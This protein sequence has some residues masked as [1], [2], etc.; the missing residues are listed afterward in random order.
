MPF[1]AYKVA[2]AVVSP[3]SVYRTN[4]ATHTHPQR[5]LSTR[6]EDIG[7][8]F[9][10]TVLSPLS[11]DGGLYL[12]EDTPRLSPS[13]LASWRDLSLREVALKIF[14]IFIS[15]AEIPAEHLAQIV[16]ASLAGIADISPATVTQVDRRY[17]LYI[18]D[19]HHGPGDIHGGFGLQS[20]GAFLDYFLEKENAGLV[21]QERHH[22]IIL[23]GIAGDIGYAAR[24]AFRGRQ[25]ISLVSLESSTSSNIT[26]TI[27][28]S[29]TTLGSN[30]HVI[31]M[32]CTPDSIKRIARQLARESKSRHV[33][34]LET[35]LGGSWPRTLAEVVLC[36]YTCINLA[37][38]THSFK[39]GEDK[40]SF[41]VPTAE[42]DVMPAFIARRMGLP[43]DR[44]IVATS[45]PDDPLSRFWVSGRYES[46]HL[47]QSTSKCGRAPPDDN[48]DDDDPDDETTVISSSEPTV[49]GPEFLVNGHI[50]RLLW[51]LAYD[52]VT[53][54][55]HDIMDAEW[56]R[57]QAGGEI[58]SW[59][60]KLRAKDGFGPVYQDV[61]E[62]G[63]RCFGCEHAAPPQA[64]ATAVEVYQ[65]CGGL[66]V[67]LEVA[68]AVKAAMTSI[69][70]ERAVGPRPRGV[71]GG[72]AAGAA[73]VVLALADPALRAAELKGSLGDLVQKQGV[74]ECL[75][76][77]LG[78]SRI[79]NE[80]RAAEQRN[81]Y[82]IVTS[83]DEVQTFV[84]R[85]SM[86]AAARAR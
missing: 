36:F 66:V 32:K 68:A 56:D 29:Q 57:R 19:L 25:N 22:A 62:S 75:N 15:S 67:D 8:R 40:V 49:R 83:I 76:E 23:D 12:P 51:F 21:G 59:L 47:P 70:A 63:R 73:H 46:R 37:K 27:S 1:S 5:Y 72:C 50:E 28:Q 30:A 33:W 6:G 7:F 38:S 4:T 74:S 45:K 85:I 18:V 26:S 43:V 48:N 80:K 52:F 55:G 42:W 82:A 9:E 79:L 13:D 69:K 24:E 20:T 58:Q 81:V 11:S 14:S 86:E 41:V 84:E 35:L 53:M 31:G 61:L 17:G 71:G 3:S 44:I 77:V 65:E 60:R 34:D 2:E 78:R 10:D 16:D 54:A 39:L 64:R